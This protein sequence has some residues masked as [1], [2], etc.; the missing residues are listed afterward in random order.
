MA[1]AALN[2][3]QGNALN[4]AAA[5]IEH[6]QE[7]TASVRPNVTAGDGT[8]SLTVVMILKLTEQTAS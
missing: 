1:W 4:V 5:A 3:P 8:T 2:D 7:S 6:V